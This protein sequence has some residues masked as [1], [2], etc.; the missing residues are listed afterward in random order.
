[1]LVFTVMLVL[2]FHC[3]CPYTCFLMH[4]VWLFFFSEEFGVES[5]KTN[6]RS[7]RSLEDDS[8]KH[9]SNHFT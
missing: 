8:G 2:N 9:D 5:W 1:M 4:C 6:S 7:K 3:C